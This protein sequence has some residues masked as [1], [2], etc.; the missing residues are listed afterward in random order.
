M[1]GRLVAAGYEPVL[2]NAAGYETELTYGCAA[3]RTVE[4]QLG[5][6]LWSLFPFKILIV[7][8]FF[9]TE[10]CPKW[11]VCSKLVIGACVSGHGHS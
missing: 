8:D 2:L 5:S 6:I 7:S 11:L 4:L 10:S 9:G 3:D 1:A